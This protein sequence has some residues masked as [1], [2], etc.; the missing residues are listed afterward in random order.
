MKP[1]T[2]LTLATGMALAAT[3]AEARITRVEITA[4]EDK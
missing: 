3:S 2:L 4:T 1:R